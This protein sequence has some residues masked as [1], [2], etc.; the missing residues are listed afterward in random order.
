MI[1]KVK[2]VLF[3]L[4]ANRE[5]DGPEKTILLHMFDFV[6][7]VNGLAEQIG[8]Q[9]RINIIPDDMQQIAKDFRI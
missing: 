9:K 7:T 5:I 3:K 8:A 2:T 6:R 4:A 1:E